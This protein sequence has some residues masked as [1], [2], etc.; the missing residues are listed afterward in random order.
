MKLE[1]TKALVTLA[2]LKFEEIVDFYS[3]FLE[4]SPQ[5]YIANSYAEYQ[6][7][8]M[9]LGIFKPK[10]THESEFGGSGKGKMSICLEVSDLEEAITHISNIGYPTPKEITVASHGREVYAYDPDGNRIILHESRR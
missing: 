8:G 7:P 2:T 3:A 1:C 5:Q 9:R 4:R 10:Q 6:L